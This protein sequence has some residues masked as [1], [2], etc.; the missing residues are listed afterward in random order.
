[1]GGERK[2]AFGQSSGAWCFG[3]FRLEPESGLLLRANQPVALTPKTFA[4][5]AYLAERSGRLVTKDELMRALWSDAVVSEAN[6]TQ[7]IFMLRKAL[8]DG[9]N[10]QR[11]IATVPGRGYRFE[12]EMRQVATN[13]HKPAAAEPSEAV[14]GVPSAAEPAQAPVHVRRWVIGVA[15]VALFAIL[16]V[17]ALFAWRREQPRRHAA[18]S[19]RIMLAVLPFQNLTG[20]ASQEYFSDGLTEE[21]ISLL[22]VLDPSRLGVIARTS[23]MHYKNQQLPLDQIGR[24]LGV[25]YVLEGS[26]RRDGDHVRVT[27]QLIQTSDQTHVWAREYDREVGGLLAIQSEIANE[28]ADEIQLTLGRQETL[29]RGGMARLSQAGYES[30]DLYLEGMFFLNKRTVADLRQAIVFFQ[31]A[32]EKD[33]RNARAWAGIADCYALMPGYTGSPQAEFIP[34]ARAAALKSLEIDDNLAEA[35][36]ALALILQNYDWDWQTSEREFRRAIQLN[37]NDATAHQWYA[38]HLMWRGR[39]DEALRESE[40]AGR[41]DPL[42]LI[43]ASDNGAI[44]YFS[45]QYDRAIE[46][47]RWVLQMNPQFPRAHLIVAAYVEK[48]M[49]SEANR[50]IPICPTEPWC[51]AN[52]AYI[53]GRT[54]N[55]A[56]AEQSIRGLTRLSRQRPVD[57]LLFA[58][59]WA[60]MKDN[61]QIL[62]WLEKAY[63]QHS[64]E[65]VTLRVS[66]AWDPVRGDPRFRE[67]V[68]KVNLD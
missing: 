44:Y 13:G 21:M 35:H 17:G 49:Y 66:P 27:A 22:G 32:L 16:T 53:Y 51:W 5:L 67:L 34:Q 36:A 55:R 54:G 2:A 39:F 14:T 23:V 7:T 38:E 4:A 26:V 52:A 20:D 41:L 47:W 9:E 68:R 12:A 57:P 25:N 15:A 33:P 1:M 61:E 37:P 40:E 3:P 62:N 59:A 56:Q 42:S 29:P 18:A 48:G 45:R 65:I 46:K 11:Y 63:A 10:G 8:A 43:V 50:Q 28:V 64:I 31:Q 24:E 58:C 19:G 30:Y 6:L 60:G